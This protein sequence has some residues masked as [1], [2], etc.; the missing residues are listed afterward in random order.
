MSPADAP[1][2]PLSSES[3]AALWKS[4]GFVVETPSGQIGVVEEAVRIPGLDRPAALAVCVLEERRRHVVLVPVTDVL[5]VDARRRRIRLRTAPDLSK[6][7][8]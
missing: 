7:V 8:R 5:E 3:A 4:V 2:A 1:E 6:A